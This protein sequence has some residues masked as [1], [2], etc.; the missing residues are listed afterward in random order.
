M[1]TF[2]ITTALTGIGLGLI[3]ADL[4]TVGVRPL[5]LGGVLWILVATSSLGLQ[6]LTGTP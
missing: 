1:G 2:N 4:R 5:V 3:L 6:A